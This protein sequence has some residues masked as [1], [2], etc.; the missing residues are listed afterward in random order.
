MNSCF[1]VLTKQTA[2][3]PDPGQLQ[4]YGQV[5]YALAY[6][7]NMNVLFSFLACPLQRPCGTHIRGERMRLLPI[8]ATILPSPQAEPQIFPNHK[9]KLAYISYKY[10]SCVH[11]YNVRHSWVCLFFHTSVL[12]C[13]GKQTLKSMTLPMSVSVSSMSKVYGHGFLLQI[14]VQSEAL[15][16]ILNQAL[17]ELSTNHLLL[18]SQRKMCKLEERKKAKIASVLYLL[19]RLRISSSS[20]STQK[21]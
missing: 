8:M 3:E 7:S 14:I 13:L 17:C 1:L 19:I 16:C 15:K 21:F 5:L 2:T 12:P 11:L 10:F 9:T 4:S 20:L 6:C 18:K